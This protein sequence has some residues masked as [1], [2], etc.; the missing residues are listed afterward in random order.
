MPRLFRRWAE[1]CLLQVFASKLWGSWSE[2]P[3]VVGN[4]PARLYA[5][6]RLG[7]IIEKQG[8]GYERGNGQRCTRSRAPSGF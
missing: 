2:C 4:W 6:I 5:E 8:N 7:A 3:L 1:P